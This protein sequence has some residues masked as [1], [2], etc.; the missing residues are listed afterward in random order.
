MSQADKDQMRLHLLEIRSRLGMERCNE[1]SGLLLEE[2]HRLLGFEGW[3][4]SFSSRGDEIDMRQCNELLA[5]RGRLALPRVE[6]HEL[7]LHVV[8]DLSQLV[9]SRWGILEPDP[10][11]CPLLSHD[12]IGV[13]LVPALGFDGRGGRLGYGMGF[14]DRL[15]PRLIRARR[16]GVGYREQ[17]TE[18]LPLEPHDVA[19][20]ELILC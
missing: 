15:L 3:I 1:A 9:P 11:A 4:L 14:Y 19:I 6:G 18:A 5:R 2:V 7:A 8:R 10:G 13:A 17:L 12:E 20:G 16:F